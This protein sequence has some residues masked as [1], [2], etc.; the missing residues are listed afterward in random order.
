MTIYAKVLIKDLIQDAVE[1]LK[2]KSAQ[3]LARYQ[4]L[5]IE[6]GSYQLEIDTLTKN[7]N[8]SIGYLEGTKPKLI[9]ICLWINFNK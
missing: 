3:E 1:N 9:S 2:N 8:E 5:E 4:S 7:T 6:P